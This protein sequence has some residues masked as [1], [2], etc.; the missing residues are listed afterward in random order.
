MVAGPKKPHDRS[1]E[2]GGRRLSTE[3]LL[4]ELLSPHVDSTFRYLSR[5]TGDQIVAATLTS[6]TLAHFVRR[7][8]VYD[9]RRSPRLCLRDIARNVLS[10][11][12]R[13]QGIDPEAPMNYG[14]L[15]VAV[16]AVD[17]GEAI[18][19]MQIQEISQLIRESFGLNE[20]QL[21]IVEL[22]IEGLSLRDIADILHDNPQRVR[23]EL[24]QAREKIRSPLGRDGT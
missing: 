2:T 11:Y 14:A 7:I 3:E 23:Q 17:L 1:A 18:A 15:L 21:E 5:K 10:D 20:Y 24:L 12:Q 6:E 16:L 13:S 9:T 19:G 8:G 4:Y 22:V